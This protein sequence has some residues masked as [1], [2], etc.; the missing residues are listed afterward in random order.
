MTTVD[1]YVVQIPDEF[2]DPKTGR[3]TE[4]GMA[5]FAYDNRWKHDMWVRSG[6]GN[7][8]IT[9]ANERLTTNQAQLIEL[10]LRI[11]SGDPLT[12]DETGFTVDSDTLTVDM[13]EA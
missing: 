2:I 12:S 6:A 5:W 9:A 4:D 7:D 11:G 10:Q 8:S 3:L 13:I 1:P